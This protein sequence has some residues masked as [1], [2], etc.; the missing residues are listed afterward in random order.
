MALQLIIFYSS[1]SKQVGKCVQK[2]EHTGQKRR[3]VKRS[4]ALATEERHVARE[5]V[6]Y[7]SGG[8]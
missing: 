7:E 2:A 6:T 4:T 8:F 1:D 5:G 3:K